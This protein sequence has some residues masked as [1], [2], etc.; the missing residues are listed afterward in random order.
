MKTLIVVTNPTD[1][2][3]VAEVAAGQHHRI[4]YV[5]LANAL[6]TRYIDYNSVPNVPLVDKL[7]EKLRLNFRQAFQ[8]KHMVSQDGYDRVLSM[9]ERVGI[10]LHYLL[11]R[12]TKH[13]VI[14]H[15]PLSPSKLKIIKPLGIG[16][17][18]SKILTLS[19]AEAEAL[20]RELKL[21]QSYFDVLRFPT[22]T[23]FYHPPET[24]IPLD[25]QDHIQSL[26]NSY[27][28]YPTLMRAMETLPDIP[29]QIRIGSIWM[30]STTDAGS[31]LPKNVS[32]QP[33]AK[34]DVLRQ[35]YANSRFIVIPLHNTTHWSAGSATIQQ[36]M[37]M[38]KAVITTRLPGLR[39]YMKD[40]VHGIL[41]EPG[42]D[43]GLAKAIA[44]LWHNPEKAEEMG[45]AAR[46][47]MEAEFSMEKWVER[48]S[49]FL[50]N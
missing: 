12:Q 39:E 38:G 34:P 20:Q 1:E 18:F 43:K 30:K 10:T 36:A 25:Q 9:S 29:C 42:D 27:R 24:P 15:H 19:H 37:A 11:N 23:L 32:I 5:E 21:P 8:T 16:K 22:D 28:D 14:M 41:V 35:H 47:W 33:F 26:G 7:E 2:R 44:D 4:D 6:H 46:S 17:R 40:G 3:A 31:Q 13:V 48:A 50:E 49:G 45:R